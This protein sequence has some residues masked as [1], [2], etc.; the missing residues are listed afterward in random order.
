MVK[1]LCESYSTK[2]FP[3]LIFQFQTRSWKEKKYLISLF[4]ELLQWS[5]VMAFFLQN[6]HWWF[7]IVEHFLTG[8]D[9]PDESLQAAICFVFFRI[10]SCREGIERLTENFPLLFVRTKELL[11]RSQ[12]ESLQIN[13]LGNIKLLVKNWNINNKT[14][15]NLLV[16]AI[17][18][19][20]LEY[21]KAYPLIVDK[22]LI[23]TLKTAL[24]SSHSKVQLISVQLLEF[25]SS[26][27]RFVEDCIQED[28]VEFLVEA[29]GNATESLIY[30][31]LHLLARYSNYNSFQNHIIFGV[32]DLM[33]VF[34]SSLSSE[35]VSLQ[36]QSLVCLEKL[37]SFPRVCALISF[38]NVMALV[39]KILQYNEKNGILK[40]LCH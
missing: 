27:E 29:L 4:G 35:N 30:C 8:F 21:P 7:Q 9:Y 15:Q 39:K 16:S 11:L 3:S 37:V 22:A 33:K 26:D 28:I 17:L 25:L 38:D 24:L 40:I 36:K 5:P 14:S 23:D 10:V 1:D 6:S 2:V 18:K 31:I 19:Y 13:L 32:E 20:S 34:H 12:N